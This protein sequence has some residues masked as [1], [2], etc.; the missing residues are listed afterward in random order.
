MFNRRYHISR[1]LGRMPSVY[2][3]LLCLA[4]SIW[5]LVINRLE[6]ALV[7]LGISIAC[8]L[9]LQRQRSRT[10]S[11]IALDSS[12]NHQTS[13]LFFGPKE[14]RKFVTTIRG[15]ISNPLI[16]LAIC[17]S[18][19]SSF[20][21]TVMAG[22]D[23]T[24]TPGKSTEFSAMIQNVGIAAF[25]LSVGSG[26][27][28]AIVITVIVAI[29]AIRIAATSRITSH[30]IK[31]PGPGVSRRLLDQT[32]KTQQ[33]IRQDRIFGAFYAALLVGTIF[34]S[35]VAASIFYLMNRSPFSSGFYISA[36]IMVILVLLSSIAVIMFSPNPRAYVD[37]LVNHDP[38]TDCTNMK[39]TH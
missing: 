37:Y 17:M 33:R 10:R 15:H 7:I 16:G 35:S 27:I 12:L 3:L 4:A 38:P 1:H 36:L 22:V 14:N 21:M 26:I 34:S 32:P 24:F 23:A 28:S 19:V 2:L 13:D 39:P 11:H 29:P 8:A 25:T 6:I 18:S 5:I 31:S 9:P 30:P 20:G